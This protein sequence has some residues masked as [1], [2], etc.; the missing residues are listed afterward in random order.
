MLHKIKCS[1]L[2]SIDC[3]VSLC[4]NF[5]NIEVTED[6]EATLK[7][8]GP[9]AKKF[10]NYIQLDKTQ[11]WKTSI[12][13]NFHGTFECEGE[14]GKIKKL[15]LKQEKSKKKIQQVKFKAQPRKK[16]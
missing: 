3:Y 5:P 8:R 2:S 9:L 11:K 12:G 13:D 14:S 15:C 6:F 4:D 1:D 16:P 7:L 10:L